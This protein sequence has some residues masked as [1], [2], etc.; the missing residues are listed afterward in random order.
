MATCESARNAALSGAT[1][2][3][4]DAANL[5]LSKNRYPSTGGNIGATGASG[6]GSLI[7][8]ET[9]SPLS[10]AKA[11]GINQRNTVKLKLHFLRDYRCAPIRKPP[12]S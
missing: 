9:D 4:N 10:G 8:V 7:S 6:G 3:A 1:S 11:Q 2:A 5:A 12:D